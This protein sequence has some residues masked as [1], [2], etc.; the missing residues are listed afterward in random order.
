MSSI[1]LGRLI[2]FAALIAM[3]TFGW[4]NANAISD[5]LKLRGYSPS[6]QISTLAAEDTMTA[7]T[8]HLFYVDHPQ[9]IASVNEF[10]QDCPDSPSTIVLGCYHPGL[11]G[12]YIYNVASP[13]LAGVT[14]VTAAHEVLHAVYERLS[15]SDRSKLNSELEEYYKNKL[16]DPRVLDE[17]RIYQQTE[18][19]DVYDEMSCTFGTEIANLPTSLSD[20]YKKYF[21]DRLKVVAYETQYES[22]FTSRQAELS[23]DDI[24]LSILKSQI[25]SQQAEL[26]V[27]LSQINSDKARLDSER[28]AGDYSSYNSGVL[29]YNSEIDAY[30]SKVNQLRLNISTYNSLVAQRNQIATDLAALQKSLDTRTV[31]QA[32]GR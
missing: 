30:N 21:G 7:Y 28:A 12:I 19:N 26:Q 31:P 24:K 15:S 9:L 8:K 22:A 29:A 2:C 4:L 10:R 25:D 23:A 20:Y 1:K 14:Q 16:S 5:W 6:P 32:V 17:V 18:P 13:K 27:Q 11:N 3:L